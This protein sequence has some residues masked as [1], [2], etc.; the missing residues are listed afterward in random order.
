MAQQVNDLRLAEAQARIHPRQR[1]RACEPAIRTI[2]VGV[3]R[4]CH[5]NGMGIAGCGGKSLDV[6]RAHQCRGWRASP[7]INLP[8]QRDVG[9]E[10]HKIVAGARAGCAPAHRQHQQFPRYRQRCDRARFGRDLY[11]QRAVFG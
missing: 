6:E 10:Q 2:G 3:A 1:R 11:V 7:R 5:I 4:G 9:L 8:R